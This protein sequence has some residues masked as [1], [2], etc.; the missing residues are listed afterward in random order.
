MDA[1]PDR[2]VPTSAPH[3]A[4]TGAAMNAAAPAAG[5]FG[6]I[7]PDVLRRVA[8]HV[9]PALNDALAVVSGRAGLLLDRPDLD[10]PTRESLRQIYTASE[11]AA[12]VVRELLFASG[13]APLR[14]RPLALDA[15][16]TELAPALRH[17]AGEDIAVALELGAGAV[18]DADARW[19]EHAVHRLAVHARAALPPGGRLEI[20]TSTLDLTAPDAARPLEA[21]PGQ[22]IRLR[23]R[24]CSNARE[25]GMTPGPLPA[26]AP[27]ATLDV[28]LA[29]LKDIMRQH[30]G[31]AEI[32]TAP[33]GGLE[34][35]L[36]F[37]AS[38]DSAEEEAAPAAPADRKT[39]GE[40]ILF[41]E[42]DPAMR[43]F[44]AALLR[45]HGYRV[46]QAESAADAR[47]VWQWHG[48]R[49]ALLLTD[50]VLHDR[51]TGLHLA[52]EL[53]AQK[54]GLPVLVLSGQIGLPALPPG[55]DPHGIHFLA[56]PCRPHALLRAMRAAINVAAP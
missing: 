46:L 41:V 44:T 2:S 38:R 22:F 26:F 50:L 40:A 27:L 12:G 15:L 33:S 34:L 20:S 16:L 43:E 23:V 1:V 9:V 35:Q 29:A 13:S 36:Y 18:I 25:T 4:Q 17:L 53:R 3:P 54:P 47:E 19:V 30:G 51:C 32:E 56:K 6:A 5:D 45:S 14:I 37:A 49:I 21:P 28:G 8:Q 11:R 42:D 39:G 52:A 48:A 55:T 24:E 7:E 31:W 10:G